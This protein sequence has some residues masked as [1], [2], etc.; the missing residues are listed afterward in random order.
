MS[1][2]LM[3]DTVYD[4]SIDWWECPSEA[5]KSWQVAQRVTGFYRVFVL[6]LDIFII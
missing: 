3:N 6:K 5:P 1:G 4:S 2:V